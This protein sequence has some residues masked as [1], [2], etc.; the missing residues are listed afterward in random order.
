MVNQAIKIDSYTFPRIEELCSKL[1]G[2][3]ILAN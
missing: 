3:N 1:A 2:R